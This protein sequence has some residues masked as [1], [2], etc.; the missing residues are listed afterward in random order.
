M[1]SNSLVR[2]L[3]QWAICALGV[4][5]AAF[6][7]PGIAYDEGSDLVLAVLLLSLLNAFLRPLLVLFT[8]PFVI[9][10]MGFGILFINALLFMLAAH[11]VDGFHVDGFLSAFFGALI[12]SLI[13]LF[14]SGMRSV[15]VTGTPNRRHRPRKRDDI[16]DI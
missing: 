1:R 2:L 3:L 12:I 15:R 10:T 8:L 4:L 13:S 5:V 14:L 16:I 11:W 6:L 7:I 9:L